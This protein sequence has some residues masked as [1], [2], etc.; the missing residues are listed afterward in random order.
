MSRASDIARISKIEVASVWPM[1]LILE[2]VGLFDS[3]RLT[4]RSVIE[5]RQEHREHCD[6]KTVSASP[7]Y[8]TAYQLL[9]VFCA[10]DDAACC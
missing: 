5:G 8:V 1:F 4:K 3:G 10:C 7:L 2:T 9:E 6:L